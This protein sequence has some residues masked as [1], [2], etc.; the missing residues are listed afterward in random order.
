MGH[1]HSHHEHGPGC[2]CAHAP[3][4][5][6]RHPP[7]APVPPETPMDP[8]SQA[9]ATALR[10]SFG[11]VKVVMVLLL[12]VFLFSGFFTVEEKER[13]VILRFGKPVGEGVQAL[14]GP[15]LHFA[16]PYPIDEVIKVPITE[17]QRVTS[18][19]GWFLTTPEQ[20][21]A[22]TEPPAGPSLNPAMDGYVI[23]ADQNIIHARATLTY[24]IEDPVRFVFGFTGDAARPFSGTSASNLVLN[25]LNSALVQSAAQF[26]VDDVLT[27]DVFG[28]KDAVKRR[29]A[30]LLAGRQLGVVV[31]QL[32]VAA[33][34][35][36]FLKADFA[37]VT[38]AAQKREKIIN[39]ARTIENQ[40]VSKA[41]ADAAARI[42]AAETEAAWLVESL[43]G[44]AALF[45]DLLPAYRAN[46]KLFTEQRLTET[47]A[48]LLPSV[49]DKIFLS[50]SPEGRLRELR[51]LL[52]RE[53]QKINREQ[54]P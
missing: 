43:K 23:T 53:P 41:G 52:N 37:R 31:E 15:G 25:A 8:G 35:P 44:E 54:K 24:R 26:K 16:F 42:N 27:R 18:T 1:D 47:M 10:S 51:L 6:H 3:E 20:E 12:L 2:G 36:L 9:L 38:D 34:P 28:F 50:P 40:T 7:V 39:E 49:Q 17:L 22:G 32:E 11:I 14:V 33:R 4:L 5:S 48:R 29:T 21:L 13:A 45:N 46:P 19:V 30:E